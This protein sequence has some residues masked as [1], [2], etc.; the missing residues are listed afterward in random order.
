[1]H[2]EAVVPRQSDIQLV[3]VHARPLE[4]GAGVLAPRG[5]LEALRRVAPP[6]FGQLWRGRLVG[7]TPRLLQPRSPRQVHNRAAPVGLWH[8]AHRGL[9]GPRGP[10]CWDAQRLAQPRSI[11]P[12]APGAG[13]VLLGLGSLRRR[14]RAAAAER[15]ARVCRTPPPSPSEMFPGCSP[16]PFS[17]LTRGPFP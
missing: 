7:C 17:T 10:R 13:P 15:D 2:E 1:M 3:R 11:G 6:P 9:G 8:P 4:E 12:P 14:R 16:A 5:P